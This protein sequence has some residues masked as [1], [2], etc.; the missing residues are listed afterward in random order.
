[1]EIPQSKKRRPHQEGASDVATAEAKETIPA[2]AAE[3]AKDTAKANA[4]TE[5]KETAT[6]PGAGSVC[7]CCRYGRVD[8]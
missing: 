4:A 2:S 1:M 3:E 7:G 6:A 8:S 5:C